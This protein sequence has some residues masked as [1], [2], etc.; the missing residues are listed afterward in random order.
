[1]SHISHAA[2]AVHALK[3]ATQHDG[4][5]GAV[6]GALGVA[7]TVA[8]G[9][10]AFGMALTPIGWGVMLGIGATAGGTGALKRLRDKFN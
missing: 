8:L 10:A 4:A 1:M 6:A 3:E 9:A 7:T 2:H 5:E